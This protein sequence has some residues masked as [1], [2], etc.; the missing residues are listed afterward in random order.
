MGRFNDGIVL[1]PDMMRHLC[2]KIAL[3]VPLDYRHYF[4]RTFGEL[5]GS[6]S[7]M[8]WRDYLL[9]TMEKERGLQHR[10]APVVGSNVIDGV[11]FSC[12]PLFPSYQV[13]DRVDKI[14]SLLP[15]VSKRQRDEAM[16]LLD[17]FTPT[18]LGEPVMGAKQLQ[19]VVKALLCLVTNQTSFGIDYHVLIKQICVDEGFALPWPVFFGDSNWV[20]DAF[21]FVVNPGNNKLELWRVDSLALEGEPMVEWEKWLNGSKKK[22][23][24]GVF[25]R[26]KEY[27]GY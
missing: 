4:T 16:L 26:P 24:W 9:F 8:V 19:D 17:A 27:V 1:N 18:V 14:L 20:K 2:S 5:K 15:E 13:R 22:P 3:H 21:A 11:L 12:L 6:M 7:P 10:G 23:K 25:S